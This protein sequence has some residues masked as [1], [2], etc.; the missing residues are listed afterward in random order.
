MAKATLEQWRMLKAVIDHGGFAQAAEA[1]FKSQ[2]TIN[3]AVHKLQQQLGV[4]LLE[5]RGRK[6]HLTVE[7]ELLLRRASQ[8]LEQAAA[9]EEVAEGLGQGEEAEIRLAVDE[10]YPYRCLTQ[11]LDDFSRDYPNTRIQLHETVLSG[12]AEKLMAGEVDLLVAGSAP[13]GFLGDYLG[14]VDFVAV[15]HPDHPLQKLGRAL[16]LR[17][18]TA[19]RQIVVRDSA[20]RDQRDSGWLDAEQRWT[21]SHMATSRNM[22]ARG[23]GFAWLPLTRIG[24]EL[25]NGTLKALPLE[26]ESRRSTGVY[27]TLADRDKAGPAT[28][29]L[30]ERL[31]RELGNFKPQK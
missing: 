18:L 30:A 20:L 25:E 10:V 24:N 22:I 12:G 11:A 4:Q 16:N 23:M 27:L 13:A 31:S 29:Q 28:R 6:A 17:D 3:H 9:L 1:I 26:Q 15:S 7:G 19:H 2:S 21:V 5:V 14:Q 8:L